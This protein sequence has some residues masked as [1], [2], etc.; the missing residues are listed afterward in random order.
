MIRAVN[1]SFQYPEGITVLRDL[2]LEVRSGEILALMGTNG[3][4]KTT[5]FKNLIGLLKPT[6]GKIML[7][8]KEYGLLKPNEIF[9]QVG[10]VFQ[11]PNDQLFAAT[12]EQ[13]VAMGITDIGLSTADT[14]RRVREALVMV[15]AQ[16]LAGRA[17]HTLSFGQKKRVAIA[18]VLAMRPRVILLDEP[19]SG[20]DPKGT[21]AIMRL[22]RRLNRDKGITMI[23]ATHDIELVPLY[24]DQVA[25]LKNGSITAIGAP[26]CIL[27]DAALLRQTEMRLTRIG[28]LFEILRDRNRLVFSIMPLTIGQ[29][30]SELG[31]L[32][33]DKS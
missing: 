31:R 11:D 16:E 30:R 32:L 8:T 26:E 17:I 21:S 18:G 6:S 15:D 19:T 29:A 22:L 33:A 9:S 1:M 24:C 2:N 27:T 10:M 28:H 3:C 12:V 25:L 14:S 4:G 7:D 13:D 5:L 23:L 20:L